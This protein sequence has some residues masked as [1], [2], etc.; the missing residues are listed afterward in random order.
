M[1]ITNGI[2]TTSIIVPSTTVKPFVPTDY[3][4]A[5]MEISE[6]GLSFS[7]EAISSSN[8]GEVTIFFN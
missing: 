1:V 2:N 8:F 7:E 6:K 4:T 3:I 5:G